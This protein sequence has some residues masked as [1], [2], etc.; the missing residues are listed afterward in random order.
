MAGGSSFVSSPQRFSLIYSHCLCPVADSTSW[1]RH[2]EA[3]KL[4]AAMAASATA[5]MSLLLLGAMMV[6]NGTGGVFCGPLSV[7]FAKKISFFGS[8]CFSLLSLPGCF[9]T[10]IH[11]QCGI[12]GIGDDT[13][14]Q[15][16]ERSFRNERIRKENIA[17]RCQK[18]VTLSLQRFLAPFLFPASSCWMIFMCVINVS[19]QKGAVSTNGTR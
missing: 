18:S 5:A 3:G 15:K 4:V 1:T 2:L 13:V 10:C 7:P 6:S 19:R 11:D 8:I 14:D 17:R 9:S 12:G 16:R